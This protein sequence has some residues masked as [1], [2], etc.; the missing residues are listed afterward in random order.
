MEFS[1]LVSVHVWKWKGW[2][3]HQNLGEDPSSS[4]GRYFT[5][6]TMVD[7]DIGYINCGRSFLIN[8][9]LRWIQNSNQ[10]MNWRVAGV[11]TFVRKVD[12]EGQTALHWAVRSAQ[13]IAVFTAFKLWKGKKHTLTHRHDL[14]LIRVSSGLSFKIPEENHRTDMNSWIACSKAL[15][16]RLET[17]RLLA[18]LGQKNTKNQQE[19]P[20]ESCQR[21]FYLFFLYN[22]DNEAML[23][24]SIFH[25]FYSNRMLNG[26]YTWRY[27]EVWNNEIWSYSF[28]MI[29]CVPPGKLRAVQGQTP[30]EVAERLGGNH[31]DLLQ[32]SISSW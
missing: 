3:A 7:G 10:F 23:W 18:S 5:G 14:N 12:A 4:K 19:N 30:A 31:S 15:G 13:F 8:L 1:L 25:G 24:F 22:K 2:A 16:G 20:G 17:A 11:N 28:V 9:T 6:M 32:F 29:W 26:A 21:R 27:V